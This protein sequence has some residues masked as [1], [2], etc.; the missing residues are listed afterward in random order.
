MPDVIPTFGRREEGEGRGDEGGDLIKGAGP[1]RAQERF[2]FGERLFDGIEIGT[3]GRQA[4]EVRAREC[5]EF[6]V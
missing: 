6:R 3:V 4:S 2:Q 1:R 5:Q